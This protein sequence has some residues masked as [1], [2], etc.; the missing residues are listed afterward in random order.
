VNIVVDSSAIAALLVGGGAEGA[1][2][3]QVIAGHSLA[4]PHLLH[5]EVANVL[6]R[7]ELA[8]DLPGA[9]TA[10][11]HADLLDISMT[12]YPYEPLAERIWTLRQTVTTYDAWY[13]ALAEALEAPLVTL[14]H[15]LSR[16]PGPQCAFITPSL[17]DDAIPV[18]WAWP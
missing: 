18:S 5:V 14:D 15:R 17:G 13:V 11:A 16:A 6:R 12:L 10:L 1:W 3:E 7:A 4:A 9:I 8:G 2:A